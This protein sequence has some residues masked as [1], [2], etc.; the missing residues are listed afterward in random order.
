MSER[1]VPGIPGLE[2]TG[3]APKSEQ[4]VRE[5]LVELWEN[6]EKLFRQELALAN[7][8]LDQKIRRLKTEASAYAVGGAL[9]HAAVFGVA[10][11]LIL[12]LSL[13]IAPWLAALIVTVALAAGGY[14]LLK[15]EPPSARALTPKRTI[16]S[17]NRDVQTFK[18][19][20]K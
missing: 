1:N 19:A 11:T 10:A 18:E 4:P 20:T 12:L 15:R 5:L 14:A 13:A 2:P 6:S 16:E 17:V 8:E 7:A 3:I 9:L